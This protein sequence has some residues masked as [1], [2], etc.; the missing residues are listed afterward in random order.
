[1]CEHPAC[2]TDL[3]NGPLR[4]FDPVELSVFGVV[5]WSEYFSFRKG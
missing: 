4:T 2:G 5:F 3:A 1:M